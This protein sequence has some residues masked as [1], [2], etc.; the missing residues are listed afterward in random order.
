MYTKEDIKVDYYRTNFTRSSVTPKFHML[1]V[2]VVPFLQQWGLSFGFM[3]EHEG[4]SIHSQFRISQHGEYTASHC[5]GT[6]PV[7]V[8]L[9]IKQ[10]KKIM[11]D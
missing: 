11:S 8:H 4:E 5:S 3:S 9:R 7:F 6:P 2:H 10:Q 1:E